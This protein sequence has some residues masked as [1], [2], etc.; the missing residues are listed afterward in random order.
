MSCLTDYIGI[1]Y[2]DAPT[3]VSGLYINSLPG[4]ST[5]F[6]DAVADCEQA[7]YL[8]MWE[9]VQDRAY[10]PFKTNIISLMA[11]KAKFEQELYQTKRFSALNKSIELIPASAEWRGCFVRLPES[12]YSTLYIK[13]LI[14]YSDTVVTTYLRVYD[15]QDG[16]Q[17]YEQEIDLVQGVNSI[18]VE[19][20]F[21]QNFG[22][23]E[24]F[25]A[26]DCT[27]VDT[28]KTSQPQY[29]GF[30]SAGCACSG[31]E[32]PE[33]IP[34]TLIYGTNPI[35]DNIERSGLGTGVWI[36]ASIV[37]SIDEFICQ[38]KKI[39]AAAWLYLLGAEVLQEK[40]SGYNLNYF[41]SSN[42]EQTKDTQKTFYKTYSEML[43][44]ALDGISILGDKIC[45]NCFEVQGYKTGYSLP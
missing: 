24:I 35:L 9:D 37:C 1:K 2:T 36:D 8:G 30:Y 32:Y 27:S 5:E 6:I 14:I 12:K 25:I 17:L 45:F 19:Q 18:S 38:N 23:V 29:I 26:V 11:S 33:I 44:N 22:M 31:L 39:L 4:I 16:S 7:D 34:A 42:L 10:L 20:V 21:A 41:S 43:N 3:P 13:N 15:T 28:I 40:I